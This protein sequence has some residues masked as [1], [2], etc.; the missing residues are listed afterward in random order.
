[1]GS[2]SL[3]TFTTFTLFT[4]SWSLTR[5]EVWIDDKAGT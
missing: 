1:M 2:S 3:R 5:P 4:L